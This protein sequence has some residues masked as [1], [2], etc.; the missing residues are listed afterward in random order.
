M[1]QPLR[2]LLPA[3]ESSGSRASGS[4]ESP[5]GGTRPSKRAPTKAACEACRKR[6]S[7]ARRS[8]F[9]QCSAERPRC[10]ICI[11]RNTP[12]E[13]KTLPT[14]TH[15]TAQKRRMTTLQSRC[16]TFEALYHIIKAKEEDEA[17]NIM[18][19]IR[20]GTEIETIVKAVHEG[21]PL[22]QLSVRPEVRYRYEFPYKR[23]M[24]LSLRSSA[25]SNPYLA[26]N[27]YE[28]TYGSDLRD[29]AAEEVASKPGIDD[30]WRMYLT[31]YH[32]VELLDSRLVLLEVAPWTK[33]PASNS[34]LRALLEIYFIFEYPFHPFFHKDLFLDDMVSGR[35][36]YCSPLLVNAVLAAAWHGYHA[37]QTR[38]EYWRPD[39]LGYRFLAEAHRLLEREQGLA[40][41]TTAQAACIMNVTH[42]LNGVDALG[43]SL[44]QKS[45]NMAQQLSLFSPSPESDPM[46]QKAA[47][48]TSWS[49]F[50][51]QALQCYH[52]FQSPIL[53]APPSHDLPDP[54]LDASI[55]GEVYIKYP[56]SEQQLRMNH[57]H[58]F[59]AV[60]EFRSILNA[61]ASEAHSGG[62]KKLPSARVHYYWRS[63]ANWYERL[64]TCLTSKNIALP[65]HLKVHMHMHVLLIGIFEPFEH[66]SRSVPPGDPLNPGTIVAQSK[67]SL[68]T[69]VRLYYL[70]HG[71]ESYDPTMVLF[72]SLLAWSSLRDHRK[73]QAE[74]NSPHIDAV[75]STLV[76]CAKSLW[77]Q[78][79]NYFLSEVI[80]RLFKSC[81]PSKDEVR[82]LREVVEADEDASRIRLMIQ[83]VRSTWPVGIFSTAAASIEESRLSRFIAWC[84][85]TLEDPMQRWAFRNSDP[86]ESPDAAWIRYTD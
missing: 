59:R 57:G 68:E 34:L 61:V 23:E 71:F 79:N 18:Q 37:M 62:G 52:M 14:E 60:S 27:L 3:A 49:I 29:G 1:S 78:G 77:D 16:D 65:S 64:P 24:P 85:Q 67:A 74:R 19:R 53:A 22:L 51:W 12:C 8:R 39:N 20:A 55:Y 48:I 32:A 58:V 70:R 40:K 4:P 86:P 28:K 54:D 43:W 66:L 36:R 47:A 38:A 31:P 44:L 11:E 25:W 83:E 42:W 73:M 15:L 56:G 13:Y 69:L 9:E 84:E 82:L 50:N 2:P 72:V 41:I 21:D 35:Q 76:L 30:Q 63:I 7:K 6:K 17:I 80:F 75:L 26:S 81:L 46:W 33:V 10:S 5:G 45:I